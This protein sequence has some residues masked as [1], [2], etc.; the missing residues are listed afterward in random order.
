[1][2]SISQTKWKSSQKI[3]LLLNNANF[4]IVWN[5]YLKYVSFVKNIL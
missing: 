1:M 5:L 4:E 3:K 2:F